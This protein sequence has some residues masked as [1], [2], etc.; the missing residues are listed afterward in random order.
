MVRLKTFFLKQ[1]I[2]WQGFAISLPA[3]LTSINK[4]ASAIVEYVLEYLQVVAARSHKNG[5][6]AAKIGET[7]APLFTKRNSEET[8]KLS[9]A[10]SRFFSGN[11]GR[12]QRQSYPGNFSDSEES[13]SNEKVFG[14]KSFMYL[15]FQFRVILQH[16]V[17]LL[18]R[19]NLKK[20]A[21]NTRA[22]K[23]PM[24]QKR[25]RNIKQVKQVARNSRAILQ[26]D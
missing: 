18:I 16:A 21:G 23:I 17:F 12:N 14:T 15:V 24:N 1:K 8:A 5:M 11:R 13:F 4:E 19:I 25:K 2:T 22:V 9:E 7:F 6:T 3:L 10:I 20:A 26:G